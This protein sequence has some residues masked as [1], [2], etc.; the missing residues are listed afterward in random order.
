LHKSI[1]LSPIKGEGLQRG[2]RG[3]GCLEEVVS[4]GQQALTYDKI[5]TRDQS[6]GGAGGGPRGRAA[7]E[8]G[9][10]GTT[11]AT[12]KRLQPGAEPSQINGM[13]RLISAPAVA[14]RAD[15]PGAATQRL[16]D[17]MPAQLPRM[18]FSRRGLRQ[19]AQG[20]NG[21]HEVAGQGASVSQQLQ[22]LATP[23]ATGGA[24]LAEDR[25]APGGA[26]DASMPGSRVT[27]NGNGQVRGSLGAGRSFSRAPS[28]WVGSPP[29][30]GAS[31][32]ASQPVYSTPRTAGL[33]RS[34][35]GGF[36]ASSSKGEGSTTPGRV[37][38]SWR[39]QAAASLR[40]PFR[41]L[42]GLFSFFGTRPSPRQGEQ[43]GSPARRAPNYILTPSA[44][45][46]VRLAAPPP[47]PPPPAPDAVL[48]SYR[49]PVPRHDP[50]RAQ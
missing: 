25:Q 39:A 9:C 32:G 34:S 5:C 31:A 48:E 38:R 14:L 42:G 23:P 29:A 40:A 19:D 15:Q 11:R 35:F 28:P 33:E 6:G 27:A 44:S 41:K 7:E 47:Y 49:A 17:R 37:G 8:G 45:L 16:R 3:G 43:P 30:R 4:V 22:Q 46:A 24:A 2:K 50:F 18:Q 13:R 10:A 26:P 20:A 1:S 36:G 21:A 12:A